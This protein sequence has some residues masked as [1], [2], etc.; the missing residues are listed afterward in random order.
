[1][2]I[3]TWLPTMP[4]TNVA[5]EH[6]AP[7]QSTAMTYDRMCIESGNI[8]MLHNMSASFSTWVLLAGFT[9]LPGTFT[10]LRKAA[11]STIEAGIPDNV[12]QKAAEKTPLLIIGFAC[13][14]VGAYGMYRLWLTYK[15]NYYWLLVHIFL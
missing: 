14:S 8:P 10:S 7:L 2:Q 9:I 13:C 4:S 15:S 6:P 5:A 11:S 1:M 3:S 12:A